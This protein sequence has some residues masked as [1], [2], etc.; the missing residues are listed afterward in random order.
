MTKLLK[1]IKFHTTKKIQDLRFETNL[2]NIDI[3]DNETINAT[4][5]R[6][7]GHKKS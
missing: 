3:A 6:V 4:Y 7:L 5:N 1:H 2:G